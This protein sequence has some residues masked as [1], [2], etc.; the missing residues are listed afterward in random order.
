MAPLL[1]QKMAGP[2]S[3]AATITTTLTSTPVQNNLL[4]MSVLA[5]VADASITAP[6]W[7]TATQ[8]SIGSVGQKLFYKI[9][10][11]AESKDCIANAA[12]A[13]L[14]RAHV[15][16]YSGLIAD[17]AQV[18]DKT[19]V[20]SDA[21]SVT[22]L[23]TGPTAATAQASELAICSVS[24]SVGGHGGFVS[25]SNGFAGQLT[26]AV[27]RMITADQ[28]RTNIG[29]PQC[30]VTWTTAR[31]ARGIIAT[32]KAAV[33]VTVMRGGGGVGVSDTGTIPSAGVASRGSVG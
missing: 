21:A 24:M 23:L 2:Q 11:A 27:D 26:A 3:A 29:T 22:S 31:A 9:A 7:T 8:V 13:T 33:V 30:T 32:F 4:V 5:N 25:A 1:V 28:I 10:G 16:E 19:A 18:L 14:M 17:I 15:L 20:A 6:G 12:A